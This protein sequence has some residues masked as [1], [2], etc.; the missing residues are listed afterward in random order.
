MAFVRS[1]VSILLVFAFVSAAFAQ[2]S[3]SQNFR[4]DHTDA[5]QFGGTATS[6]SFTSVLGGG[7]TVSGDATS[8]NF[9]MEMGILNFD[10]WQP[11]QQNW[12]WYADEENETPTSA[13]AAEN[14]API[15]IQSQDIIKLRLAIVETAGVNMA[16]VK[17]RLEYSTSSDFSSSNFV[18]ASST[19]SGAWCY[20][21]GGGVDNDLISTR[22]LS[23]TD[24]C[25]L[26]VGNGCG[27]HNE[28]ATT[29]SAFTHPASAIAEYEFT[30]KQSGASIST[31]YYFRAVDVGSSFAVP[32]NT[33]ETYPSLVTGGAS[34][35]FAIAG[36]EVGTTTE[37]IT[38]DVETTA[39]DIPFGTLSLDTQVDAAQRLTV[40]TEG[41]QGYT[42]YAYERQALM[43]QIGATIDPVSGT[44]A[45]PTGW[46]SGC[47]AGTAGCYGYHTGDDILGT[48][49][50]VRFA[51]DDR[52]AQLESTPY[53]VAYHSGS[54]I[55]QSTDIVYRV[56]VAN[57]QEN[58][59]YNSNIVYIVVPVI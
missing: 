1:L 56:E 43:N 24:S 9:T 54:V 17:L 47:D 20:A 45:A 14:S 5:D 46:T 29:S 10:S 13:L 39:T 31:V 30:I 22:V 48:G 33:S 35:D 55:G 4:I 37:G 26:S 44:N 21:N 36:L 28:S 19:C 34:L 8:T 3:T 53:E 40:S 16:N 2:E 25:A 38:T 49:D 18:A 12:R 58:G 52:F 57:T 50:T 6:T 27:T 15:D 11:K 41:T 51:A 23:D 7:Q 42:I 59:D 32:L